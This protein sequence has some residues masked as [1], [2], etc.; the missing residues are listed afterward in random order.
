MQSSD[1]NQS[2][3][4]TNAAADCLDVH[5]EEDSVPLHNSYRKSGIGWYNLVCIDPPPTAIPCDM[6]NIYNNHLLSGLRCSGSIKITS[7]GSL[8]IAFENCKHSGGIT[9][10][11]VPRKTTMFNVLPIFI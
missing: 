8:E 7:S 6:P 1:C 10:C 4:D 5:Y 2:Y 11:I 3:L 9:F